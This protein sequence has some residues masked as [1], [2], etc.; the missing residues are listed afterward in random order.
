[1]PDTIV[2]L[3]SR[4]ADQ[5]TLLASFDSTIEVIFLDADRDGLTQIADALSGKSGYSSIQIFSHGSP[6]TLLLGSTVLNASNL[7]A[8]AFQLSVIGNS[9]TDTGDLLLYGC[10]V[11]DEI[12]GQAFVER[13]SDLTGADVATSDDVSGGDAVGGDWELEVQT[14]VI[15]QQSEQLP[16]DYAGVLD[17]ET[18]TEFRVN[19]YVDSSQSSP[20]VTSL[21]DGGFVVT[22]QS[23]GQD[24]SYDGIYGQ[25]YDAGGN[26]I[27][28]EFQINTYTDRYQER[29]SVT[30]LSDGGFVVTWSSDG[31]DGSGDGIYGQRYDADGNTIGSEFQINSYTANNQFYPSVTSLSDGGFVVTWSSDGQDGSYDGI[32]GQRYD[33][34]G[35]TI[36]SE[37]QV[38]SYTTSAQSSPSVT[39]LSDGGFVVTWQ[40]NGQDSSLGGIYGQ[41]YDADGNTI[42]SEF[43]IN[44]YTYS[45]QYHP[46]MASLSDGGFV[47]AWQS[48]GQDGSGYG[49]YGQRYDAD[50]NTIGSEFQINSYTTSAQSDPSV[51]LLSDGGFVVTWQSNGQD[52]SY[53]GIY[54]QRY[55]ADGNTIGSEFQI[56]TYTYSGQYHP[57]MA[58]LSDGGFVVTWQSNG[59]DGSG[60]GIY[61]QRYDAEGNPV[62]ISSEISAPSLNLFNGPVQV[63]DENTEVTITLSDLIAT[64]DE[65]DADGTVQAFRVSSISSG[66]LRIGTDAASA[67]AFDPATNNLIDATHQAYWTPDLDFKGIQ[68]A[69]SVFAV[70]NQGLESATAIEATVDV[71][72]L[73]DTGVGLEFQVNSYNRNSQSDP[74][75]AS[76]YGGGFVVTWQS[77]GQDGSSDGIYGQ[78]YDAD[79]NTVGSEFQ[80]NTYTDSEQSSPSVASLS[81]GGFVVTWQSWVDGSEYDIYGQRY[82]ASGNTVGSEFQINT[83]TYAEQS[84]PSVASLSD[85][86]FVVTWQ[87]YGQDGSHDGIYGQRYDASG[88]A[89]GS[90]FQIN[91]YTYGE[92]LSPSVTSLSDGGFV[93]TWSSDDQD[94]SYDGIY[95]QRYDA[96]GNTVGSE[97]QINT[98]TYSKQS[99]PS[100][101]SLSDGG[102]VVT[103][104]S[105]GQDGSYD[106][107]YGQ[108]YDAD[109]NTV[110]SEFQI[111]TYTDN[112]QFSPSVTSLA[113]G[114]FV[115]TW[116]SNGQDGSHD[117]IYGQRYDAG[118]NTVGSEFQ[119]NTY[120]D[121]Q[122][123]NPSV[124]SLSDGGFV[125][126]WSS[127]GQDG[128]HDGI[129]G[130]RYDADGNTTISSE[131]QI[132]TYTD[133]QQQNSSVTSLADGGFVVTWQSNGQDGSYDGIY[134]QRYDAGGNTVGSEFQIN[135]Y[136]DNQQQNSSVTSLSDGGFV[137]TWQ[138]NGQDESSFGIYGQRYD[139]DGNTVG[140]EFQ[141]NTCTDNLQSDPSVT[142]LS[143]GGF[144]V[145]WQ[146][147][148]QDGAYYGIYG[149]R[150]DASGNT[151][152]SE[153]QINTYTDN[154]QQNPS[155]ASLSDGGFVV[156]WQ[157]NGQDGAYYGIYGQRYDAS[158]NT[159]G[160]E[161]QINTYTDN[162][163]QN[164]SVT[165]LADGGFVVTWQSNGQ[166]GSYDG[167]YGQRYD[168]AG[169]TVGSEF[170]INTY[171][172]STQSSPSVA[173]LSD[174]GF[175][176]AWQSNGQDESSFGIYGQRYDADGNTVGSEFQIN[177]YTDNLQFSPSVTSLAD[178]GFVVTWESN[179]QDGSSDGIYGQR[180]DADGN[181]IA[182]VIPN[183]IPTLTQFSEPVE[184]T[185]E[186]T[187]VEIAFSKLMAT[188]NESDADGT[189]EGFVVKS[190]TSGTLRIGADAAS[191]T[192]YDE[193]TNKRIDGTNH[194]Y[195]TPDENANGELGAFSVVAVDNEGAESYTPIEAKVNVMAVNDAPTVATAIADASTA[196]DALYS[197]NASVNFTDV[198]A[199]DEL[200]FTATLEDGSALPGWLTID[201]TTGVLSGTPSNDD[202]GVLNVKV[203]AT[204]LAGS[205]ASDVYQ[206]TVTNEN[207]APTVETVIP[208]ASTAED[209][210]YSYDASVNFTDVD[211][212]DELSFTATLEDGSALPGWLTIDETTGVLSGTPSNDDVGVLNVRVTA[213]DLAGASVS[214]V[215]QLTVTNENDAPTV[216]TVI[217]DAS[218]A[219][220]A[221]YSYDASVNFTD[222]DA[223]DELS[224]TATQEDGS[225]LPGWLTIDETTG[226]LSGTPE[227]GDVGVFNVKVTAT[228]LAGASVSDVYQLTVTAMSV[229]TP[230][231]L[232][233]PISDT[234]TA[235]GVL[236][237]YDA[238]ANFMDDDAGDTLTYSATLEGGM[239]LP[240]WLTIDETTGVLSGTPE[241]G[242][243]NVLNVSVTATDHSGASVSDSYM[244]IVTNRAYNETSG[245]D[246]LQGSNGDDVIYGAAGDD[247]LVG[248]RG[249]DILVGGTGND[250]MFGGT[251]DDTYYVDSEQDTVI[252]SWFRFGQ[253]GNDTVIASVD[254][255]LGYGIENLE[256][257]GN[258][259]LNGTG[260]SLDNLMTGNDGNNVL[261]G[262]FGDD[263]LEG[264]LGNDTLDGGWGN[265]VLTGGEGADYLTGGWGRDV[266]R[267][268]DQSESGVIEEHMDTISDFE[269]RRDKIDL[270]GIDADTTEAGDQAFSSDIL[271]DTE[272][273]TEA[274]QLRFDSS[275][276][277]LYGNTDADT[278]SEFAIE[279]LGVTSVDVTALLL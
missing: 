226:V 60:Y 217:P 55:D 228:D 50:G 40:S 138:S 79:G 6:G 74:S 207:D 27:G 263:I 268:T 249:D 87:S 125:V 97:F 89:I 84:S 1:M 59:Q 233:N 170:Q 43:Q 44:T 47:V 18:S 117:G 168:A 229:N 200:S 21:S 53:D 203:T 151:I 186:D 128:S 133:N 269:Y 107:I 23:N 167:I 46:S 153:F 196:E 223:G 78:R 13:L 111:N 31:Q 131:F 33:A 236:Y 92:Q 181:P 141:I 261:Q 86:G 69:F 162:Q 134:G 278:D 271:S 5:E 192:P 185:N 174:G 190:V 76:L 12:E 71:T 54:G 32:Y 254:W 105:D 3:D 83:Y 256:L 161:F 227:N 104:S 158:G 260:N 26:T 96:S 41:R 209:A 221:A 191:A 110:G 48:Y 175:V 10:N 58:S 214:D 16:A 231:Q 39:S 25:R 172:D 82:D 157:S 109:G 159:V 251:G 2:F 137:V 103:W 272:A 235:E 243:A 34:D 149:Q 177:T 240:D 244:L 164:S 132:N 20:S 148:G 36:G 121:N 114:G 166:D 237:S 118:G 88:N 75:V 11:G 147:N 135:T 116:Q 123:Q 108:R 208:D 57:S 241:N 152:G 270:S 17:G 258:K 274:G 143:D 264:G 184:T 61:G 188:G 19:T 119:I 24:G 99:S 126:T 101:A 7:D 81:D 15:E 202:V 179:G 220:D 277:I 224:F 14:G 73:N 180:Y 246:N 211:A 239:A 275:S 113:D 195:W 193:V 150:Y 213:T 163:Q 130:Q 49:I 154:Q 22:W 70:D 122:Q 90:E 238:S 102:F 29:A 232:I 255:T 171:T 201:E 124:T 216:E 145:T 273:F 156:T 65:A 276:G 45:G 230:P 127:D 136:T 120:T 262:L 94:G 248:G 144:V 63:T 62:S 67:T 80:I 93:V 91:T 35:N 8:Y 115:V 173:S 212:G 215:Y 42:G 187:E 52:G 77:Y 205:S 242:D 169:N 100:V 178:G 165:S 85:G 9:L 247:W 129:Y 56:N 139:A 106:G 252:E 189:V 266:F 68:G 182:L 95:G 253:S 225:A 51:A 140:S 142:S 206:L 234:S 194:A 176:V 267:Y 218:T 66:T 250:T 265:D 204:D 37:F 112:L 155:V 197:Y 72:A 160:S 146:S 198:D 222:V 259:D 199:G 98:Y 219:E 257:I 30:S 279:L 183:Q 38:N 210:A 245:D 64:G 4:V 28:S